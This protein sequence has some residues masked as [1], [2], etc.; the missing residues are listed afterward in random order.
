M[1][2]QE[3]KLVGKKQLPTKLN[4]IELII[5]YAEK[6]AERNSAE[7]EDAKQKRASVVEDLSK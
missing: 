7:E 4:L 2:N 1:E 5:E 6:T 3:N